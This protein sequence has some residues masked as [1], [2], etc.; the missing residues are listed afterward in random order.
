MHSFGQQIWQVRPK[1]LVLPAL[2]LLAVFFLRD[3]LQGVD[4]QR[5]F[6][7]LKTFHFHQWSIGAFCCVVSFYALGQFDRIFAG[8]LG[9]DL[10]R[11]TAV[12]GGWR[13]TA[14][15]QLLGFGILT[16]ALV[17]WRL[18]GGEFGVSL[19]SAT[20]LTVL[21]SIGFLFGSVIFMA[22]VLAAH[23][24]ITGQVDV[25]S[26]TI[27]IVTCLTV[28]AALRRPRTWDSYW[29]KSSMLTQC[30]GWASLEITA[31]ATVLFVF[32]PYESITFLKF[33]PVFASSFLA[34]IFS[35]LPGGAGPF[36]L[37]MINALPDVHMDEVVAA[38]LA[39]RCVYFLAPALLAVPA[40]IT[41]RMDPSSGA[42]RTGKP[43]EL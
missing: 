6:E 10:P 17:R 38:I 27:L 3:R 43:A 23:S 28:I 5:S 24:A 12:A 31:A 41:G 18:Y 40:L 20:K 26:L 42:T 37:M 32:L 19:W 34:G 16:G 13:A 11:K 1:Q 29:P 35:S 22:A 14:I 33:L 9:L 21:G 36:E 8:Q 2:A 39:Y 25:L 4:I 30:V 7:I 15:A